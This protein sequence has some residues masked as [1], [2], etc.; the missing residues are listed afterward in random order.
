MDNLLINTPE[1]QLSQIDF[2]IRILVSIGIGAIIGL[3]REHSAITEK[4]PSFAGIRTFVF[5]VLLG[6][7]GGLFYF[8]LT[9]WAFMGVLS[10]VVVLTILSYYITASKGD[11]GATTEFSLLISFFLGT[12]TFLGFLDIALIITVF[13][14][15]ML[16]IKLPLHEIVGKISIEEL[17]D[18]I[19]FIVITLLIFPFLP[20]KNFGPYN[21]INPHEIGWVVILTSGLGFIG[22]ILMKFLGAK[23]GMLLS[24]IIGGLISSTAVTWILAKKSKENETLTSNCAIAIL[25]ASSIMVLRVLIW[26]FIFNVN[27]FYD[28]YPSIL[29]IFL[30]AIGIT[31]YFYFKQKGIDNLDSSIRKDKP[32]DL[33]GAIVFALIYVTILL[34]V[35]YSHENLG[36]K[37]F[38]LSSAIAG[39]SDIDAITIT[40]SK[41]AGPNLPH[42][43][44]LNALLIA[45]L[46]NTI[47]KLSISIWTGSKT[48]RKLLFIG[49]GMIVFT[50][51]S[52]LILLNF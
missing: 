40:I 18:F 49:Y 10:S 2:I 4:T 1:F 35:N 25:S 39:F 8:I 32:L 37:G 33:Q 24:G 19:R 22:Y 31:L 26:T 14:V 3:E 44:A 52:L 15:V 45:I 46:A 27:L 41:L 34:V 16:S 13:V 5:A 28:L 30:T 29:L 51:L 47:I 20:N 36:E 9:P 7:I 23:K 50:I 43:T 48:L 42:Q 38:L 12:L 17:Y 11:I 6:F 21:I